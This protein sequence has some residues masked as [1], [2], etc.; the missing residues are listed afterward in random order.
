MH[1]TASYTPRRLSDLNR[2]RWALKGPHY[3]IKA[4]ESLTET[5]VEQKTFIS[6]L[7]KYSMDLVPSLRLLFWSHQ[8]T[9]WITRRRRWWP[10]QDA[11][12]SISDKGC[13]LVPLS[14]PDGDVHSEWRLSLSNPES[15]L[16]QLR[17]QKQQ[18]AYYFF[19]MFC[20][21][22]LKCVESSQ[23]KGKQLYSYVVKTMMLWAYEDLSPEDPIWASL[24]NSVQFLLF[25]LMGSLEA[26]FLSHY[27]IPEINL[28]ESVGKDVRRNCKTIISRRLN[29]VLM[30]TPS[31]MQE[32]LEF[33]KS[34]PYR[35][36]RCG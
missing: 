9:A 22:Y 36:F 2:L 3:P 24:E 29:N 15:I 11:I 35:I 26:G 10:Q 32:K 33:I 7:V 28:L 6:D 25:K 8:T 1:V 13:H 34:R 20:Y 4:S 19:K 21:R 12:Q 18:Q 27:F 5:T 14:F 23:P 17:S 31:D 16:A 30:S